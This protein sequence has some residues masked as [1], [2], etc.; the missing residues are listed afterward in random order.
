MREKD[1]I[2]NF[3]LLPDPKPHAVLE[4]SP[5]AS[6]EIIQDSLNGETLKADDR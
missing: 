4:K 2:F 1:F 3:I 5:K 6:T